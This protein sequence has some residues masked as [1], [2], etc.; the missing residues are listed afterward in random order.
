MQVGETRP[1]LRCPD[2]PIDVAQAESVRIDIGALCHVW[3]ADPSQVGRHRVVGRLRR[4][5]RRRADA[6][7]TADGGVVEVTAAAD[8]EPGDTGTL[9]V[10]ADNSRPGRISIR[11]VRTPPPSLA[12]IR[13]ST[14]KAGESQTI[15]LA[16]YLTPGVSNPVPTVVEAHSSATCRSR[17]A[18]PGRR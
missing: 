7:A 17:S 14:L 3:T 1:I 11:V 18:R 13:V 6:P 8:T 2:D 16:R 5:L 4:G 10:A 12:P 9:R 15:D